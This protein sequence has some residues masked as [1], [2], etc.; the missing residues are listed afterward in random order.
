MHS[1]D[2]VRLR[3]RAMRLQKSREVLNT[4]NSSLKKWRRWWWRRKVTIKMRQFHKQ[5]PGH[6][7][8]TA[9]FPCRNG[10]MSEEGQNFSFRLL[11][12]QGGR[13]YTVHSLK[14]SFQMIPLQR[15]KWCQL[16]A[17]ISKYQ[18]RIYCLGFFTTSQEPNYRNIV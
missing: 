10:L 13:T 9:W 3:K 18:L 7:S 14:C 4:S 2:C 6:Q 1:I 17:K 16:T 8:R 5:P 12:G 15:V 11:G